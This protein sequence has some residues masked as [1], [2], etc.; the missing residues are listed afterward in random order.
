MKPIFL[1]LL[2]A[3]VFCGC[4]KSTSSSSHWT[5]GGNSFTGTS[6]ILV[7]SS[8]NSSGSSGNYI[9]NI[10]YSE[11][12]VAGVYTVIFALD[13]PA[14][15][16]CTITAGFNLFTPGG[17]TYYSLSGGSVT[18]ISDDGK[19][20]ASFNNIQMT[21]VFNTTMSYGSLS[22]ILIQQ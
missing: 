6:T 16:E 7:D 15:K 1:L 20:A 2:S 9:L 4:S 10:K 22:G 8:L 21:S 3:I 12:P 13:T 11:T 17:M 19:I 18:V 5:Y 14:S